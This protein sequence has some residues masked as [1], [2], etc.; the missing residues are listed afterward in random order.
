M[1]CTVHADTPATA[2]C[3]TCGKAMC[4]ACQRTV[5][6]VIYCEDCL[7]HR[8]SGVVPVPV[9]PQ[10]ASPVLAGLLGFI[11]GVGAMYN[12]QFIKGLVHVG[13]FATLI[14]AET[15]DIPDGLHAMLGLGIAFWVFYQVFDAYKTA[16]ARQYGLPLPDPFGIERTFGSGTQPPAATVPPVGG[17]TPPAAGFQATPPPGM[18]PGGYVPGQPVAP[19]YV[20]PVQ[21]A[22]QP[23]PVGAVVLIGLGVLF[24]LNTLGWWRF[25]WLGRMWPLILIA[26]GLWLFFRRFGSGTTPTAPNNSPEQQ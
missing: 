13:I 4:A 6:G 16:K 22:Q 9:V 5:H 7:A 20:A 1:N 3:R 15:L 23:S 26:L 21:E 14:A 2:Y 24:L 12:G 11:P 18:V 25:H 10:G 8:V 17:V 19:M